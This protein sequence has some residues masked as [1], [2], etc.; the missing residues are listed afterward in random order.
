MRIKPMNCDVFCIGDFTFRDDVVI[1][2]NF[3]AE[4]N[5]F[6][7]SLEAG[8][9]IIIHAP[10]YIKSDTILSVEG[11]IELNTN[12]LETSRIYAGNGS[13]SLQVNTQSSDY[14]MLDTDIDYSL[15]EACPYCSL[16]CDCE[17]CRC[18]DFSFCQGKCSNCSFDPPCALKDCCSF[19]FACDDPYEDVLD[20]L[21]ELERRGILSNLDDAT[22]IEIINVELSDDNYGDE[23]DGDDY[24]GDLDDTDSDNET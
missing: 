22:L 7:E 13:L 8:E 3:Y 4:G 1:T 24:Y 23:F 14:V 21:D 19:A 12:H 20:I 16:N 18:S 6:V 17:N 15:D 9:D 5:V 10:K 11:S 2:G